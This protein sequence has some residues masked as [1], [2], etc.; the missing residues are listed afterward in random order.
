[1]TERPRLGVVMDPIGAIK[2]AKD[3]TLAML[4]A[5]C[6]GEPV[7]RDYQNAPPAM[8]HPPLKKSQTPSAAGMPGPAPQPSTGVEG[9]NITRQPAGRQGLGAAGRNLF[10]LLGGQLR[11]QPVGGPFGQAAIVGKN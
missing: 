4:L 1:M 10:R 2:Y 3:S 5:S 11:V 7:P 9:A 8:R 6:R